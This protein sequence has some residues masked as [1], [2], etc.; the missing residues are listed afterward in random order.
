METEATLQVGGWIM[1]ILSVGTVVSLFA[2]CLYR[3]TTLEPSDAE[4]HLHGELDI[5]T[6]EKD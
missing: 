1:M 2:W 4:E 6:Y 3:V 5:E